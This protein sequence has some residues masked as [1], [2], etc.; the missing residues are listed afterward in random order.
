MA[1]LG[2]FAIPANINANFFQLTYQQMPSFF[3][4]D[5]YIDGRSR[6]AIF[7]APFGFIFFYCLAEKMI[8]SMYVKMKAKN[9]AKN[10]YCETECSE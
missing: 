3:L 6:L 1:G 10:G 7:W 2:N 9:E 8:I 4:D 5:N